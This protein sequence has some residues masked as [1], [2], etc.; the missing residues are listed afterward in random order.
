[1]H[2][3]VI[4]FLDFQC[5]LNFGKQI[6]AGGKFMQPVLFIC[7]AHAFR[8]LRFLRR[9]IFACNFGANDPPKD[10]YIYFL[11]IYAP[12]AQ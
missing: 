9:A 3:R 11:M 2:R 12:L 7:C 10:L 4:I 5:P 8:V 6:N 1:M